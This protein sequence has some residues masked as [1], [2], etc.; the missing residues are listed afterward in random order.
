MKRTTFYLM[1]MAVVFLGRKSGAYAAVP[2][3]KTIE[4]LKEAYIGESTASARYAAFAD[5]ARKEGYDRIGLL[6]DAA[7][8]AE[9]IHAGN[10]KAVL[11]QL[12]GDIPVPDLNID[13]KTTA[14]NLETALSGE[15]YEIS[16]MYP[17]FLKKA[18]EENSTLAMISLNYAYK[19]EMKHKELY[20]KA[21][22]A[23]K[24]GKVNSLSS[25]YAVCSTCGNTYDSEAPARCGISMTPKERF[26]VFNL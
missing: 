18:Q 8:K 20:A 23:L 12:G 7:S 2:P 25:T 11:Q 14:E 26:I 22:K 17:D 9:G 15:S 13:V 16:T 1:L 21:I 5:E 24:E 3:V 4:N 19:T 10:H 6:F